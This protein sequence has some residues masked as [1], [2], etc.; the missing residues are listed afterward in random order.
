MS[1]A[2]LC[3][4][5]EPDIVAAYRVFLGPTYSVTAADG[6]EAALGV[7]AERGP[8][9]VIVSDLHMPGMDGIRLLATVRERYP[10]TVR[11]LATG[12]PDL[13]N[14]IQAVND[15]HVFRFLTKPITPAALVSAVSA[16]ADQYR[17]ILADRRRAAAELRASEERYRRLF[18]ANPHPMWVFSPDDYRFL[19]V[20][21]AAV[22]HYGFSLDQFQRMTIADL[23]PAS[24][25]PC[26]P[27]D[28]APIP[29]RKGQLR[30]HRRA[31]GG[32]RQMDLTVHPIEFDGR[33][34]VLVLAVDVTEQKVL[35]EQLKQAQK[36]E[37]IGQLAAGIAHEINTP[38]QY[39]GDNTSFLGDAL[40]DLSGVVAAFRS[41]ADPTVAVQ[42][43]EAAARA[44]DLDYLLE[45]APRAVVQALDGVKQV[46]R[47]VKAMKEFAHPGTVEKSSVDL[48]RALETITTVARNEW[49]YVADV[50]TDLDPHLPPIRGLPGELHQVFLNLL[51]NAAHA[52]KPA[53]EAAGGGKG[54]ITIST[55]KL[56]NVVEVRVAD[57]GCGIPDH[58]RGRVFDP[59]F[60]TKP[61]GQGTGQGL[62]IAHA[63]VVKKHDGV[64]TFESE[65]GKGTTF[66]VR[67]PVDGSGLSR[68]ERISPAAT[69]RIPPA[70]GATP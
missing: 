5:D 20:N 45:E 48:N 23:E 16:A 33:P 67:L 11:V 15:G 17:L 1:V 7:L 52:L 63:V 49:K 58:I 31:A 28:V 26:D 32:V 66:I 54:V 30:S 36:L 41:T 37:S 21:D 60:T 38:I 40:R 59:F 2:V 68:S 35:E 61:V 25:F 64:I 55:R 4:D 51:V 42:A 13:N 29:G 43:G 46:A 12:H 10:D 53:D 69:V 56:G 65:P 27:A 34:A 47:I 57:T 6:G 70:A 24:P 8:F 22:L 3:V 39:I 50:R 14:A 9:A 62:A 44:A 18:D 19:A